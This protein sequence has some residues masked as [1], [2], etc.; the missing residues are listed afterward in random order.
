MVEL[1]V[2]PHDRDSGLPVVGQDGMGDWR[3]TAMA[4]KKRR[5]DVHCAKSWDRKHGFRNDLP[6]GDDHKQ[7]RGQ[8]A[9]PGSHFGRPDPRRLDDLDAKRLSRHFHRRWCR[10]LAVTGPRRLSDHQLDH[11]PSV[12]K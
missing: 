4:W 8:S 9:Q 10:L 5:V 11:M 3:R 12:V 7:I 2:H 1:L 6:V